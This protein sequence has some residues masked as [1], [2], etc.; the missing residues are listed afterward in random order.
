MDL[1]A[2][3]VNRKLNRKDDR[4]LD[5][6][7]SGQ[8]VPVSILDESLKEL[9]EPLE[10]GQSTMLVEDYSKMLE[11]YVPVQYSKHLET[12]AYEVSGEIS[13]RMLEALELVHGRGHEEIISE[14]IEDSARSLT[15]SQSV[16][17][18]ELSLRQLSAQMSTLEDSL[19]EMETMDDE[20]LD[21]KV[22]E[23]VD[24]VFEEVN[25][26]Q[27]VDESLADSEEA[28]FDDVGYF[29]DDFRDL[30]ETEDLVEETIEEE[31]IGEEFIDEESI[32]EDIVPEEVSPE[33]Y[34]RAEQRM[35]TEGIR[36]VYTRLVEDIKALGLDETLGLSI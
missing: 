19:P 9:I 1:L 33:E 8:D 25:D 27:V 18:G 26:E 7:A 34:A 6:I 21:Q 36:R 35:M 32:V 5:Y 13:D 30:P 16:S 29:E 2:Y 17:V 11:R 23:A 22:E 20:A 31:P 4:L 28:S 15:N 10:D 3:A 12:G 14:L 24:A